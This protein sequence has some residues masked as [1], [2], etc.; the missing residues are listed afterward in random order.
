MCISALR[1]VGRHHAVMVL[2]LPAVLDGARAACCEAAVSPGVLGWRRQQA[3]GLRL[4]GGA[5]TSP[6][7]DETACLPV[8]VASGV[9][10]R[11][12]SGEAEVDGERGG[13]VFEREVEGAWSRMKQVQQELEHQ[14]QQELVRGFWGAPRGD[15]ARL[16]DGGGGGGPR[17]T[18][19]ASAQG[20]HRDHLAEATEAAERLGLLADS[21]SGEEPVAGASRGA[22]GGSE[23]RDNSSPVRDGAKDR[24][25]QGQRGDGAGGGGTGVGWECDV[26][27]AG[28]RVE[29]REYAEAWSAVR[30]LVAVRPENA[31]VWLVGSEALL[32]LRRHREAALCAAVAIDAAARGGGGGGR[33]GGLGA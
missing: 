31:S 11:D 27:A 4:R 12:G 19:A 26:A 1:R 17:G 23:M 25:R 5:D 18:T 16:R 22:G 24:P 32:P 33:G 29:R 30:S 10:A 8:D 9:G 7:A 21:D 6:F 20:M 28:R 14:G 2:L 15:G 3:F 13:E